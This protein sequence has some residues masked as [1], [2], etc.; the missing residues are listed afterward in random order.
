MTKKQ[1]E[2]LIKTFAILAITGLVAS[3]LIGMFIIF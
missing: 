1:R 3:S 2:K